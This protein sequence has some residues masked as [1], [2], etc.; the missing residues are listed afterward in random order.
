VDRPEADRTSPRAL[1][2]PEKGAKGVRRTRSWH[3]SSGMWA[4]I[5]ALFLS[6]TGLTWST[7][8]GENFEAA[9]TALNAKAPVLDT[10]LPGSG[11]AG[12]GSGEHDQHGGA[13][14]TSGAVDPAAF[15][16]VM[17]TA[18]GA[19]LDGPLELTAPAEPGT[20]WSAAQTDNTWRSRCWASAWP[21][22]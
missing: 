14:N 7:Y 22:S 8:A 17:A 19:G 1:F 16:R 9:L 5:G 2:G 18:R 11:A 12:G 20:A 4:L 3:A 10:A 13:Q 6:A 15:D 21:P